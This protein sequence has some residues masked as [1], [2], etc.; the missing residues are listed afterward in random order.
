[1]LFKLYILMWKIR[2]FLFPTY[3]GASI[4]RYT[5]TLEY[6]QDKFTFD[7]EYHSERCDGTSYYVKDNNGIT[8]QISKLNF[9]LISKV[10]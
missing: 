9:K 10:R 3:T 6:W 5:G 4:I 1:M 2:N 7:K 8:H